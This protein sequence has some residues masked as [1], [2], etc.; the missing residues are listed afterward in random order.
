MHCAIWY[1]FLQFKKREKH[2]W[3]SESSTEIVLETFSLLEN[4]LI[5]SNGTSRFTALDDQRPQR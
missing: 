5:T 4:A 3:G 2:P 1:H